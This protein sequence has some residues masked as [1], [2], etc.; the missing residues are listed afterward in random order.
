M[1]E[2][3]NNR[4]KR[5][6]ELKGIIRH[7]HAGAPADEVRGQLREIVRETDATEIA[8]MEQS[9]IADGMPVE[10]VRAMCDLHSQVLREFVVPAPAVGKVPPGH[11]VDTFRRENEAILAS[12]ARLRE[13]LGALAAVATAEARDRA[14]AAA[15]E[16][17]DVE[18]HYRRKEELLFPFL[19]KH[20]IVGPSKVMWAKD[21]E[22]RGFL[23]ALAEALGVEE[24]SGEEW[25]LVVETVGEPAAAALAEMVSKEEL[26][27]LPLSLGTLSADEWGLVHAES[28]RVG[29]CL[30]PPRE[31]W[32]PPLP[33]FPS[34]AL[35]LPAGRAVALPSGHL[36]LEQLQ[37]LFEA[38]PVDLTFVDAD[39]RVAFF[40]EGPD[41]VFSRTRAILGRK[42]QHCHPP[43]SVDVV[44]R[45]LADFRA[46]A[47]SV[48]EFWLELHGR[49]VHV[50]YFA[51]R[52]AQGAY[53]GCLE[54]TQDATRIRALRGERRL[55][56]Y[57]TAVT[58]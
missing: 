16:L 48:A 37:G 43:K 58:A 13:A 41:R 9:L 25:R 52:D 17:F 20:G 29:W 19:E 36:T 24:A 33:S 57:E 15:N 39:D 18:K 45:I 5:I 6:E 21:D 32:M 46:G 34:D 30:V 23:K 4:E 26:V 2:L 47:Q 11:P 51:V 55:L 1:S 40:S 53:Q 7:L 49:F 44:E 10:E 38:L 22:A 31:G 27:L 50:R 42:V 3:I 14:R 8:A 35:S 12:V 28:P 54:V 56:Q